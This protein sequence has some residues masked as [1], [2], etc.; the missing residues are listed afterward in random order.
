M[1]KYEVSFSAR[2]VVLL[3]VEAENSEAARAEAVR[4]FEDEDDHGE[5][6][7]AFEFTNFEVEE[8]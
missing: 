4:R 8:D 5:N 2:K 1:T 3:E 7:S 6:P